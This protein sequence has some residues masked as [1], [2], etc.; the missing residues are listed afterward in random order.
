MHVDEDFARGSLF[1]RRILHAPTTIGMMLG[2]L[3]NAIAGTGIGDLETNFR[4][5]HPVV[6]GDNLTHEWTVVARDDKPKYQGGIV[7]F[8][9]HS[10]NADGKEV[11]NA[12]NK[13][14][15]SNNAPPELAVVKGS[16]A[17]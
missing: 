1:G 14:L 8:E 12:L 15:I 17:P 5:L 3:G 2:V 13:I 16:N 4:F 11:V 7:T 9:G 10:V 6:V